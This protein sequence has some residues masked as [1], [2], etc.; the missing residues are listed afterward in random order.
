MFEL[1]TAVVAVIVTAAD[2][3]AV[4]ADL[5]AAFVGPVAFASSLCLVAFSLPVVQL[6]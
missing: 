6:F 4:E 3:I 5:D 1:V 2:V